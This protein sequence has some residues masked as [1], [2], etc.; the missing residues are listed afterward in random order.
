[1]FQIIESFFKKKL[2]KNFM[3]K[4]KVQFSNIDIT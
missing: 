4:Y 3:S 1:M 2:D